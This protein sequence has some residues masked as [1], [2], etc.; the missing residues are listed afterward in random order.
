[1]DNGA[2]AFILCAVA[3]RM[4]MLKA[5][6]S[7]SLLDVNASD[8]SV[9]QEWTPQLLAGLD[10]RRI[11][12]LAKALATD[13]G[14]ECSLTTA[15][16]SAGAEFIMSAKRGKLKRQSLVRIASWHRWRATEDCVESFAR[17]MIAQKVQAGVY[18]APL[19][20]D[21]SA[22]M[23]AAKAG[24][25][26][27]DGELLAAKLNSLPTKDHDFYFDLGVC[28][29]ATTPTCP[30]C[31]KRLVSCHDAD[32]LPQLDFLSLPDIT[33]RT[34]EYVNEPVFARNL[35]IER[36]CA[37]RFLSE[38]RAQEMVVSGSAFGDFTC[39]GTVLLGS[40]AILHGSV[41]ARSVLVR[42]GAELHGETRILD[43]QLR[44]RTGAD[45]SWEW[46]CTNPKG[47]DRCKLVRLAP[48]D[49]TCD[50]RVSL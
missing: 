45:P 39:D 37:V 24:I 47:K 32:P 23:S 50:E 44:L 49:G 40:E 41:A 19:G 29:T 38:V 42:P 10:W 1:M 2:C 30:L 34:D 20:F 9:P 25:E 15:D 26:T 21:S 11:V 27:V 36:N 3:T 46:R 16:L 17:R 8:D 12:E 6:L 48:H 18:I 28:G 33:F 31:L 35:V 14:Y 5:T 4:E 7:A 22:L 43:G 13:A